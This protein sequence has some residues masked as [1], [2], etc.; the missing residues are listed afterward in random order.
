[1]ARNSLHFTVRAAPDMTQIIRYLE[2]TIDRFRDACVAEDPRV[3]GLMREFSAAR[4]DLCAQSF[5]G[6]TIIIEP[7]DELLRLV[8]KMRAVERAVLR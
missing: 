5:E 8:A 3:S 2:R 6:G 1:M 4:E 7:G